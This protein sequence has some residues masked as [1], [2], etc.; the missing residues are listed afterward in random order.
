M[1]EDR[2]SHSQARVLGPSAS[3]HSPAFPGGS[4]SLTSGS[5]CPYSPPTSLSPPLPPLP[6]NWTFPH[7]QLLPFCSS[8]S[9]QLSSPGGATPASPAPPCLWDPRHEPWRPVVP[10]H[11]TG[12]M[13]SPSLGAGSQRAVWNPGDSENPPGVHSSSKI[14]TGRATG[15]IFLKF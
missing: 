9:P 14:S 6:P 8:Q 7:T 12:F 10:S 1:C 13:L 15:F 2:V 11:L 5:S 4:P 3:P